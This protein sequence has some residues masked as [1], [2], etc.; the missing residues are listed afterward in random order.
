MKLL[1]VLVR[2]TDRLVARV[3]LSAL[4]GA[5]VVAGVSLLVAYEGTRQWP[6][7]QLTTVSMVAFAGFA[8]Y[9]AA[10]SVLLRAALRGLVRALEATPH[11]HQGE[12]TSEQP[13][14]V[15]RNVGSPPVMT[16]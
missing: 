7:Q 15:Q 13:S 12:Q 4:F 1:A 14:A 9:G 16:P 11:D 2:T 10:V 3:L 5:V 8:A 6:P